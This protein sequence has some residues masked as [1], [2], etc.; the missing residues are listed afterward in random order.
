MAT[1]MIGSARIDE[2]GKLSGGVAGDQKQV[3]S[4]NDT[5]GEVSMQPFY[6]HSKG[7]YILRPKSSTLAAKMAERMIAACNNKNIGYDQGNRLGVITYGIDTKTKTECDCSSLTRQVVKEASGKDPGNFTTANA[8]AILGATGLFI[9]KISYLSQARTPVYNG[10]ILVT[11]TK[12]HIVVVVSGNPRGGGQSTTASSTSDTKKGAYKMDTIRKGSKGK[13]V[14]IWQV[15]LGYT[16]SKI[17]GIFGS[18]TEADTKTWQKAHGLTAD[19]IVGAK[20]W[21]AGL[22]SA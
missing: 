15:I 6:V 9:N 19:G 13:A 3:S 17:D 14:K 5:K 20:S 2:R 1:I 16:G 7:W 22:E 12:G 21:K 4:S 18:G 11:K 8:A 10:D